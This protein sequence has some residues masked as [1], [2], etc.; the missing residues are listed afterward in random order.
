MGPPP[1]DA[2]AWAPP[3][4][5]RGPSCAAAGPLGPGRPGAAPRR[6][7]LLD[8]LVTPV[9]AYEPESQGYL[10]LRPGDTVRVKWHQCEPAG[11]LDTYESYI[12]GEL[13]DPVTT[14]TSCGWFPFELVSFVSRPRAEIDGSDMNEFFEQAFAE[15]EIRHW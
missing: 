3:P 5:Q 4:P 12:F 15:A 1:A 7:S 13:I 8:K 9:A 2:A 11:D 10:A 14:S 6:A